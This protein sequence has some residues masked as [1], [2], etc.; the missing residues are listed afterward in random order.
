MPVAF[1]TTEQLLISGDDSRLQLDADHGCNHYLCRPQPD[2]D[3]LK[4]GS[5]TAS[6]ISTAGFAI[7][8]QLRNQLAEEVHQHAPEQ[9]YAEHAARIRQHIRQLCGL[10]DCAD[11]STAIT[12]TESGTASHGCALAVLQADYPDQAWTVL[13]VDAAE[14][15]RGVPAALCPPGQVVECAEIAIRDAGGMPLA[16]DV[17]DADVRARTE[18][19]IMQGNMVLLVMVDQSKSGCIAPSLSCALDLRHRFPDQVHLLLDACQFRFSTFTLRSYLDHGIMVAITGSKFLAAPSFAAA[20]FIPQSTAALPEARN[21][22]GLL[23]RWQI[24]LATW[25]AFEDLDAAKVHRFMQSCAQAIQQRLEADCAFSSLSAPP[26][27][28]NSA[29]TAW[30]AVPTIFPFLLRLPSAGDSPV[31]A[32]YAS[33]LEIFQRL[34]QT[35]KPRI[36]LGRPIHAGQDSAGRKLGALRLCISAPMIVDAITHHHLQQSIHQIIH[37]LDRIAI[38]DLS[39]LR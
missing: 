35:G 1:A 13:M 9:V 10:D 34:Q 26:L 8:D 5:S 22:P 19:A 29:S 21:H 25:Q 18:M 28:R 32:S 38:T 2:P 30:D 16:A 3:L 4:L 33:T 14:T 39:L 15:G 27:H 7:A 23:L 11:A 12:L 37:A 24:A 20:L 36:Q 31:H 6:T 17:I